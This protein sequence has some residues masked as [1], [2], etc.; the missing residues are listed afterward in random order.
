M[1]QGKNQVCF[2]CTKKKTSMTYLFL[3]LVH[4]NTYVIFRRSRHSVLRKGAT[5]YTLSLSLT[6]THSCP[7]NFKRHNYRLCHFSSVG[8]IIIL[9]LYIMRQITH[10]VGMWQK[11]FVIL[12]RGRGLIFSQN[13]FCNNSIY[14]RRVCKCM[15]D[16]RSTSRGAWQNHSHLKK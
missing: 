9:H 11:I 10:Y 15:I 4:K 5:T 14:I 2:F 12:L 7:A 6:H 1:Y 3:F 8:L 16:V 13:S